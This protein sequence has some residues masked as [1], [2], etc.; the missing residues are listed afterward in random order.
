MADVPEEPGAPAF[1]TS[2]R[3]TAVNRKKALQLTTPAKPARFRVTAPRTTTTANPL[4]H[5]TNLQKIETL[6]QQEHIC[7]PPIIETEPTVPAPCK[8][9]PS[10]L[11]RPTPSPHLPEELSGRAIVRHCLTRRLPQRP[12][13][14]QLTHSPP[15]PVKLREQGPETFARHPWNK[16]LPLKM[17]PQFVPQTPSQTE[18]ERLT[19]CC[20]KEQRLPLPVK[21]L[22]KRM[23]NHAKKKSK[24]LQTGHQLQLLPNGRENRPQF[25][26]HHPQRTADKPL[27]PTPLGLLRAQSVPQPSLQNFPLKFQSA[28]T[29]RHLHLAFQQATFLERLSLSPQLASET[30]LYQ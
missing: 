20:K 24:G 4:R 15:L 30:I 19:L 2:N 7:V 8:L 18:P 3:R 5:C 28:P 13:I 27:R 6:L 16:L 9:R 14:R 29:K 25:A 23:H 21:S 12:W 26:A 10:L 11:S 22:P 17:R 1:A